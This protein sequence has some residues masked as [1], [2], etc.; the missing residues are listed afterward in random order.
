MKKIVLKAFI[1]LTFF[2]AIVINFKFNSVSNADNISLE[3]KS[4]IAIAQSEVPVSDG[5]WFVYNI[6]GGWRCEQNGSNCCPLWDC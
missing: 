5:R 2:C 4:T 6:P 1:A 3:M